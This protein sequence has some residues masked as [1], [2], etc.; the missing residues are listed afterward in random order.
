MDNEPK[1]LYRLRLDRKLAGV[2]GGIAKYINVDATLI[3]LL[4][5]LFC[6]AGGSGIIVYIVA[7]LLIPEEPVM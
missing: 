3:R 6:I 7:A 1:K 4:W 5:I 2:C